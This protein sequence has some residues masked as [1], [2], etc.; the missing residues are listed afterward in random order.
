MHPTA[1]TATAESFPFAAA[2]LSPSSAPFRLGDCRVEPRELRVSRD[3]LSLKLEPRVLQVLLALARRN[4][5][6]VTRDELLAEAWPGL[7]VSEDA[8]Q[9][10]VAKLRGVLSADPK[11][12]PMIETLPKVGYRLCVTVAPLDPETT[13][14]AAATPSGPSIEAVK[15]TGRAGAARSIGIGIGLLLVLAIGALYFGWSRPSDQAAATSTP[16]APVAPQWRPLTGEPGMNSGPSFSPDG[17]QLVFTRGPLLQEKLWVQDLASGARRQLTFD[18]GHQLNPNWTRNGRIV[19]VAKQDQRC[20][21]MWVGE[22]G[23]TPRRIADCGARSLP[24]PDV[25]PDGRWIVLA[26]LPPDMSSR[27][28]LLIDI[29]TGER[30]VLINSPYGANDSVP[31]WSA[32]GEW[33]L[34]ARYSGAE[35]RE[36]RRVRPSGIEDQ[37]LGVVPGRPGDLIALAD[38][39]W[40]AAV[41]GAAGAQLLLGGVDGKITPLTALRA[42]TLELA[43][44]TEDRRLAVAT[45]LASNSAHRIDLASGE[46]APLP[47]FLQGARSAALSPDGRQVA[48]VRKVDVDGAGALW[49]ADLDGRNERLLWSAP[50]T[51]ASH[52]SFS[53]TGDRIAFVQ[54]VANGHQVCSV[55]LQGSARC[56]PAGGARDVSPAFTHDGRQLLFTSNRG[57]VWRPWTAELDGSGAT[58]APQLDSGFARDSHDGRFRYLR[59]IRHNQLLQLDLASAALRVLADDVDAGSAQPLQPV[60]GGVLYQNRLGE[61]RIVDAASGESRL[62]TT[63]PTLWAAQ[64]SVTADGRLLAYLIN[65]QQNAD[66]ALLENLDQL[67]GDAAARQH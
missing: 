62:V 31:R 33:I 59:Q 41:S 54:R 50:S 13:P 24:R 39:R 65:D 15:P 14:A 40:L 21:L 47:A 17:R 43:L 7:V 57:G 32:D 37:L 55:D 12:A 42:G 30:R 4:G 64:L 51:M 19:Y 53:P 67:I 46:R 48:Y 22:E 3:G 56:V 29:E 58:P 10:A 26:D 44:S 1:P 35:P 66:I 63:L 25:S 45:T 6:T 52:P 18:A 61:L 27:R 5:A 11:A 9:R 28:L 8:I 16:P 23:G 34:Y 60:P 20:A 38:G 2:Q 49:L 36:I